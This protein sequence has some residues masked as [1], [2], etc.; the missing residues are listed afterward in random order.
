MTAN[1]LQASTAW[2]VI[3]RPHSLSL[4]HHAQ[5]H[6]SAAR[7]G[8]VRARRSRTTRTIRGDVAQRRSIQ[9]VLVRAAAGVVLRVEYIEAFES[10]ITRNAFCEGEFFGEPRIKTIDSIQIQIVYR[11]EWDA[12]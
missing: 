12:G 5:R 4:K 9:T 8:T 1:N 11:L 6:L 7:V 2:A 3:D 10:E